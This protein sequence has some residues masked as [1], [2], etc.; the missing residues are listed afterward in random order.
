MSRTLK[1]HN[2]AAIKKM[3]AIESQIAGRSPERACAKDVVIRGRKKSVQSTKNMQFKPVEDPV[4]ALLGKI[5]FAGVPVL[6]VR[7][8]EEGR[9]RK[10]H[11]RAMTKSA[12]NFTGA[13]SFCYEARGKCG[14]RQL[15]SFRNLSKFMVESLIFE[16]PA[17]WIRIRANPVFRRLNDFLV[18]HDQALYDF[19]WHGGA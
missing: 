13:L 10:K 12:W 1:A 8:M 3:T 17:L 9:L 18:E 2:I 7:V 5:G 14:R 4:P 6:E 11:T 15:Q 19:T 16:H